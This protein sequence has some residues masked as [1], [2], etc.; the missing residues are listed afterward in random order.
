M[1][2]KK[3]LSWLLIIAAI[4]LLITLGSW[5]IAESSK[6]SIGKAVYTDEGEEQQHID[7][8]FTLIGTSE[9]DPTHYYEGYGLVKDSPFTNWEYIRSQNYLDMLQEEDQFEAPT[10][11]NFEEHSY[12]VS[13]G[14]EIVEMWSERQYDSYILLNVTFEEKHK[15]NQ[16]FFYQTDKLRIYPFHP[17]CYVKRGAE[18]VY[19][20]F[21]VFDI[22]EIDTQREGYKPAP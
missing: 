1:R 17:M 4:V 9:Y 22:N 3:Q 5:M 21:G 20:G 2:N 19:W 11:L 12:I 8:D 10:N 15:G 16:V 13:Y 7:V 18:S 6:P 14:R